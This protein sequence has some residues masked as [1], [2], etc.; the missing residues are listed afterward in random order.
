MSN[1]LTLDA[2]KKIAPSVFA[3]T[4]S[5]KMS[6]RYLFVSTADVVTP[7][8]S[9]GYSIT[10]AV[11]RSTRRD[12]RDPNFTRHMLRL[13]RN[14]EKPV[15]GEVFPEV[16]ISNSHDGQA[17]IVIHGGLFRLVC[18]NGAVV[19]H[20]QTFKAGF[21]HLGD[22]EKVRDGIR[23]AVEGSRAALALVQK[24]AKTKLTEK[25]QLKFAA[26]AA[27]LAWEEEKME[28][29]LILEAR[30]TE[31]Q[32]SDVWKVFNRIQEN[33]IRGGVRFPSGSSNRTFMTRGITH[34]GRSIDLNR[35]LWDLA[36]TFV[37]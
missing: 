27:L 30:R 3:K 17:R 21:R 23:E 12:G 13:R 5:P 24:M 8:L 35:G 28:P 4:A 33:L 16:V 32:G 25:Q 34:I 15:L 6:D 2:V 29:S 37:K 11:Q 1:V 19:G 26:E 22:A 36:T 20:G 14:D 7:L 31:D 18:S 9:Q 10:H